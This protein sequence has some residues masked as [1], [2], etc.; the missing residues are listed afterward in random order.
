MKLKM[1]IGN[2]DG[3]REGLVIA[4]S[5]ERARKAAN[6]GVRIGREAF[7]SYWHEVGP[8]D[9]ALESEVLYTRRFDT[10]DPW[11]KGRCP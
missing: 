4:S 8:V 11:F 6:L 10:K 3:T 2:L 7:N 5:K 9:P 1:W